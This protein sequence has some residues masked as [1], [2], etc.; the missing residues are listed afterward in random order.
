MVAISPKA[1]NP[2]K[3][4]APKAPVKLKNKLSFSSVVPWALNNDP[5]AQAKIGTKATDTFNLAPTGTSIQSPQLIAWQLQKTKDIVTSKYVKTKDEAI[6]SLKMDIDAWMPIEEV[7][8]LYPDISPNVAQSLYLDI[9][10]GMPVEE[11]RSL[12]PE[13]YDLPVIDKNRPKDMS[14]TNI[15]TKLARAGAGILQWAADVWWAIWQWLAY[16]DPTITVE[17]YKRW[18]EN[19]DVAA[20]QPIKDLRNTES[21]WVW[22]EIGKIW[23]STALTRPVWW[24][25]KWVGLLW[26]AALWATDAIVWQAA[27]NVSSWNDVSEWMTAAWLIWWWIPVLWKWVSL[28][29]KWAWLVANKLA[30]KWLMNT[31]DARI[32]ARAMWWDW[33]NISNVWWWLLEKWVVSS[34]TAKNIARLDD[35]SKKAYDSVRSTISNLSD[36]VWSIWKNDDVANA[37]NIVAKNIDAVNSKAWYDAIS[38][39]DALLIQKAAKEWNLTLSQAQKAKELVDEFVSIYK[40]SWEVWDTQIADLADKLR[41]WIRTTI[42]DT[43]TKATNWATDIWAL[44]KEVAI[45]KSV[46]QWIAKK[47]VANAIKEYV[48]QWWIWGIA[49][50]WAPTSI[51]QTPEWIAK[52]ILWSIWWRILWWSIAKSKWPIAKALYGLSKWSKE[53]VM[54]FAKAWWKVPM[55]ASAINEISEIIS[56][57]TE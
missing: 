26:K 44:N 11:A 51:E 32:A 37:M 14:T 47:E 55:S 52:F 40:R 3:D 23:A 7:A 34:D 53:A 27:Y 8:N 13:V 20:P 38:N 43:V 19:I 42:E 25:A 46:R 22:Q 12:Y 24:W 41:K 10:A 31:S 48:V 35:I 56:N 18:Q 15:W 16:I 36:S 6:Q 5:L 28:L 2:L 50:A 45:A 57:Q 30:L 21:F 4:I 17:E 33:T 9:Q 39:A 29:K 1:F 49:V 54:K